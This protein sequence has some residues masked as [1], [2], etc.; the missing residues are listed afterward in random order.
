MDLYAALA[1]DSDVEDLLPLQ[2]LDD[3]WMWTAPNDRFRHAAA[4]A[5]DGKHVFEIRTMDTWNEELAREVLAFALMHSADF[6]GS[7]RFLTAVSGFDSPIRDFDTVASIDPSITEY[8]HDSPELTE[9]IV[10]VFPAWYFEF[11]D[12][13]TR[14]EAT[15]Q[16][17]DSNGLNKT[18]LTREPLPFCR[19]R[20]AN[21]KARTHSPGSKRFIARRPE[22]AYNLAELSDTDDTSFVEFENRLGEVWPVT[23]RDG[24]W[25]VADGAAGA[26]G[27]VVGDPAAPVRTFDRA[28]VLAFAQASLEKHR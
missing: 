19:L 9:A 27:A 26:P 3:A 17:E 20:Y 14:D 13:A 15:F 22:L 23:W 4:L 16:A 7:E 5:P 10:P 24:L 8:T 1:Q 2:G 28:A 12:L 11:S 18:L 21:S 6:L 25:H